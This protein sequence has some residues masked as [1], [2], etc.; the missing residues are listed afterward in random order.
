MLSRRALPR[1]DSAPMSGHPPAEAAKAEANRRL[2]AIESSLQAMANVAEIRSR[3]G[4]A[5]QAF[6]SA[7]AGQGPTG[8]PGAQRESGATLPVGP[9]SLPRGGPA[10]GAPVPDRGVR[11]PMPDPSVLEPAGIPGYAFHPEYGIVPIV[12]SGPRPSSQGG[13]LPSRGHSGATARSAHPDVSQP[14]RDPGADGWPHPAHGSWGSGAP[15][16]V[17]IHQGA[18]GAGGRVSAGEWAAARGGPQGRAASL[19]EAARPASGYERAAVAR[20]EASLRSMGREAQEWRGEAGKALRGGE[21]ERGAREGRGGIAGPPNDGAWGA[22]GVG[23]VAEGQERG[24]GEAVAGARGREAFLGPSGM[25]RSVL[26]WS[27][28]AAGAGLARKRQKRG[29]DDVAVPPEKVREEELEA[30]R[31]EYVS[32]VQRIKEMRMREA[33]QEAGRV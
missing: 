8:R 2:R 5:P 7:Q 21:P 13:R 24:P 23:A 22:D 30:A 11:T 26:Q 12:E 17:H 27:G 16:H 6:D 4:R 10:P 3:Q 1:P 18:E 29:A 31:R 33:M 15:V 19:H 28:E 14:G 9:A 32:E 20:G 25:P